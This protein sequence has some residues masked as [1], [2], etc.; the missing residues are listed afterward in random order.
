MAKPGY[1][2]IYVAKT[3]REVLNTLK[4]NGSY[5]DIIL[6]LITILTSKTKNTKMLK[7]PKIKKIN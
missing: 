3:T 1:T 7:P 6:K 5:D 2:Y 4:G